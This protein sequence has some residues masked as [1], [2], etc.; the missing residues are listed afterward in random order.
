VTGH[1]VASVT[2]KRLFRRFNVTCRLHLQGHTT[3]EHEMY[4][5]WK[6]GTVHNSEAPKNSIIPLWTLENSN[7]L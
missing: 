5:I 2:S 4:T 7:F 1:N 3:L 6:W